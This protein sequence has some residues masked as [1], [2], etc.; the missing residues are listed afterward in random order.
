MEI[1]VK[2]I[3]I[4]VSSILIQCSC[5]S[6]CGNTESNSSMEQSNTCELDSSLNFICLMDSSSIDIL[7]LEQLQIYRYNDFS[8]GEGICIVNKLYTEFLFMRFNPGGSEREFDTFIL[9]DKMPSP[10]KTNYFHSDISN[11]VSSH[12]AFIGMNL[13]DF[14]KKYPCVVKSNIKGQALYT[15]LDSTTLLYNHFYFDDDIL[16]TIEI[17]YDW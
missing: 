16:K 2:P 7:T 11:F 4:L 9:T 1:K 12:G 10:L 3:L 15:Q 5:N 8:F 17:G 13:R 14:L 6:N